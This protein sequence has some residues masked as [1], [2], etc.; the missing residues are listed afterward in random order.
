MGVRNLDL[1]Y[2]RPRV[3]IILIELPE[4]RDNSKLLVHMFW[5]KEYA[6]LG[7]NF[8]DN[9]LRNKFSHYE[10]ITRASRDLQLKNPDLRGP[11]W[12]K[13]HGLES[14]VCNQLQFNF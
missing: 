14:Y 8:L 5:Q 6:E 1:E 10:T 2:A 13:R 4:T 3:R 11:G 12:A 9:F 7:G